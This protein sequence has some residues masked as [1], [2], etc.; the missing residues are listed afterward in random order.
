MGSDIRWG[1]QEKRKE[2]WDTSLR[3]QIRTG[4]GTS[5]RRKFQ[6]RVERVITSPSRTGF[7]FG[8]DRKM[9]MVPY[10][11]DTRPL[12]ARDKIHE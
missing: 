3:Y 12:T 2:E 4:H 11:P 10:S 5:L 7:E 1:E 6:T 9:A 8:E